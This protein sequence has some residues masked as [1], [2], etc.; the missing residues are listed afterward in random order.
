MK[1]VVIVG[2][3]TAGWLTAL[4]AQKIFPTENIT[5]IESP[6]IGILG[7]GEGSTPRLIQFFDFLEIPL[8]DFIKKTKSTLKVGIKFTNWAK[9]D[10]HYYHNFEVPDS[11]LS[12]NIFNSNKTYYSIPEIETETI[13]KL[14]DDVEYKNIN[15]FIYDN[16]KI[17]FVFKDTLSYDN[18]KINDFKSYSGHSLHFDARL[19]A[20]FLSEVGISRGIKVIQGKVLNINSQNNKICSLDLENKENI[21]TDFI[22]DCT[23]FARL[24]IGKHYNSKWKTFSDYLPMKKA[25]PFFLEIEK[26]QIPPYTEAIAMKHGWV[27]KIPLQHRYGCGYVFDSDYVSE[28][29][30][31]KEIEDYFKITPEYPRKD[32]GAFSFDPGCFEE[33]WIENCIAVGLSS[34]FLE[35]LEATSI[36][37]LLSTLQ[38]L[39]MQKHKIFSDDK[40]I[41]DILNRKFVKETEYIVDFLSLHYTTNKDGSEF[42]KDFNKKNKKSKK[43]L[44]EIHLLQNSVLTYKDTNY[45]FN[46]INYYSVAFGNNIIDYKNIKEIYD[47]NNLKEYKNSLEYSTRIKKNIF[48]NFI[49]HSDFLKYMG[50]LND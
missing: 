31:K 27:W 22:F 32:K 8:E 19:L 9:E 3:G 24:F 47:S 46:S 21:L 17:P 28:E 45:W 10:G 14:S 48:N 4:Y 7:A 35:P 34:G 15:N 49:K 29:E 26:E 18:N 37:Q 38:I 1:N 41:K 33:I 50:G 20:N 42:W 16:N 30:I 40:T 6:E 25:L 2:G 5:L 13:I 44:E 39:F 11:L 23:G 12:Q 36:G 43:L